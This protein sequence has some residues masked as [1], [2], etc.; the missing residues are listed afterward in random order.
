MCRQGLQRRLAGTIATT[1]RTE[2]RLAVEVGTPASEFSST[3]DSRDGVTRR[4]NPE[5]R[6]DDVVA[7]L[8]A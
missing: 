3:S 1:L 5:T 7:A 6:A 4:V 2:A 8:A